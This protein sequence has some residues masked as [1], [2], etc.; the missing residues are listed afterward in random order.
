MPRTSV[1]KVTIGVNHIL[2]DFR[3]RFNV[4]RK[5]EKARRN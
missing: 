4:H 1:L 5:E 3:K 2:Y